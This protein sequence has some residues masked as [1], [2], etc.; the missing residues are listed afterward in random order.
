MT[1]ARPLSGF[2][3]AVAIMTCAWSVATASG[4][5]I[6][7]DRDF[8]AAAALAE[9]FEA[10]GMVAADGCCTLIR[11]TW[12][13][14]AAHVAEGVSPFSR[15]V[16]FGGRDYPVRRVVMHPKAYPGEMRPG[17]VDLALLELG[18][19][20]EGINPVAMCR[21]GD[22]KG[23]T[24][25]IVGYG[26]IGLAEDMFRPGDGVRHAATNLIDRVEPNRLIVSLDA[27]PAGTELE[28]VG[29]PGDSGG[30]MYV[31]RDGGVQLVGVSSASFGGAPNDYGVRDIYVRISAFADWIDSELANPSVPPL[32]DA[33]IRDVDADGFPSTARGDCAAA[34]FKAARKGG[35]ALASFGEAH[36]AAASRASRSSADWAE[37]VDG[38]VARWGT[39]QPR[40][41]VMQ[42]DDLLVLAETAAGW[43]LVTFMFEP[44]GDGSLTAVAFQPS[45]APRE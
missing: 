21:T 16:Q 40:Q 44:D 12:V 45:A 18:E 3:G 31:E 39:L 6:R 14:T 22:E 8:D 30:P 11:P 34:F 35:E 26:D 9:R 19:P 36:R 17:K 43:R 24:G 32:E 41:C 38:V 37:I 7:A 29:A 10:T 2:L 42:G 33:R 28:G 20:V 4:V 1:H 13:V 23:Q 27:P 15:T 25:I 5:V